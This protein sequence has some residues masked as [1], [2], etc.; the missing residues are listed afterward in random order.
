MSEGDGTRGGRAR[1]R[2]ALVYR[3]AFVLVS[4]LGLAANLGLL[5]GQFLPSQLNYYTVL[6]NLLCLVYFAVDLPL[7]WRNAW[8]APDPE[9]TT[10]LP[11]VKG[12]VVMAITVTFLVFN[13]AL[14]PTYIV[15]PDYDFYTLSNLVLHYVAPVAV[16]LD[17]LVFDRKGVL[18]WADPLIWLAIPAAFL[19]Y[20][21]LHAPFIG[22]I[23]EPEHS[24]YPYPFLDVDALGARVA[25]NA[26]LVG[27]CFAVVGYA[28]V[29]VDRLG[30]RLGRRGPV[31]P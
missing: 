5:H 29:G 6:S 20:T 30:A 16:V 27:V 10:T 25:V 8:G 19:L 15:D 13:V 9:R 28:V 23:F 4:A 2:V 26:A 7:S 21:M 11:R 24:R 22:P 31:T 1:A 12:A 17:W 3:C 14:A 18:R